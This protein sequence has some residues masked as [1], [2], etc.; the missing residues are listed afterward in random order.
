M[1]FMGLSL[2]AN[3]MLVNTKAI[4]IIGQNISNAQTP[5]YSRQEALTAL[6]P[7]GYSI[8]YPSNGTYSLG[9]KLTDIARYRSDTLDK[10]FR[11]E[12]ST[13]GYLEAKLEYLDQA[14]EIFT[15]DSDY[16]LSRTLN[17]FWTS[18]NNAANSPDDDALREMVTNG[19][20]LLAQSINQKSNKLNDLIGRVEQDLQSTVDEINSLLQD[21]ASINYDVIRSMPNS[22]ETNILL[23]KKDLIL[24]ELSNF[25]NI[26]VDKE[27][28]NSIAIYLDGSPLIVEREAYEI[29]LVEESDGS[30]HIESASGR[31]L[32]V[33][34]G[35]LGGYL[36][37]KE[38]YL[39]QY[40]T[41]LDQ[42]TQTF[43]SEVNEIHKYGYG[44]DGSTGLD[45]FSGTSAGD[46]SVNL[47]NPDELALS[48]PRITSTG[49]INAGSDIVSLAIDLN[50][51]AA[52]FTTAPAANGEVEINGVSVVWDDSQT[53]REILDNIST[54]TGITWEFDSTSQKLTF[55]S[56]VNSSD[57]VIN[58]I[59]GNFSEFMNLDTAVLVQGSAGDGEN[60]IRMFELQEKNIFGTDSINQRYQTIVTD[61]GYDTNFV[62]TASTTQDEFLA[63][64][65][66]KR[67][68]VSG[69]STDEEAIMM[70]KYQRA[71]QAGARLASVIDEMLESM[72]SIV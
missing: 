37:V 42:W 1:N 41:N 49:N 15:E 47:S 17:D 9:S 22:A 10:S 25:A 63:S 11:T 27:V 3:T 6:N 46:I 68:S 16:S 7:Y 48:V 55:S 72:I 23:D 21:L 43:I 58:D 45:F 60:G 30:F 56:P 36:E 29:K 35:E 5:G 57:I 13:G 65:E 69:V 4:E 64:L 8:E 71:Y 70:M 32:N 38:T 44:L 20:K 24:D 52:S 34:G 59:S 2:A 67:D 14:S 12:S 61:V 62:K 53:L 26:Q 33:K 51:Q 18:W 19:G 31:E 28:N 40:K 39:D 66:E 50:T 54:A